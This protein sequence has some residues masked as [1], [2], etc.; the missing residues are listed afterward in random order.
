MTVHT[1]THGEGD[2]ITVV[3]LDRPERRNAVDHA[4][5]A[6]LTEVLEAAAARPTRVLVLTGSAG[7]FCAG[8]DLTGVEDA[9]FATLL[10]G[11]LDRLRDVSFPTIAAIEGAALGAGTQLAVACDLRVATATASFGIPAAKLG[12]MVNHWTV[13]R[14]ATLAGPSTARAILLAA[15]VVTGAEALRLGLV[16]REGARPEALEWAERIAALAPLTIAGHKL[17]L[18]RLEATPGADDEI[19]AAFDRAWTSEDFAEGLDAFRNRRTP[20]FRGQ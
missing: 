9:S 10:Q 15:E 3:T 12:L 2:A 16:N 7:H 4:T 14:V 11:V 6:E 13:Q 1:E 18:N 5:L 8:A 17:M 20:T 19:A